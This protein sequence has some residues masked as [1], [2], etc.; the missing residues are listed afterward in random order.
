VHKRDH[1]LH[2]LLVVDKPGQQTT[3]A[4]A[5]V[6]LVTE[7]PAIPSQPLSLPPARLRASHGFTSHDIVQMVR[8]W[9][10][11]RQIGHTGTLD[12][13][14]SGV[15]VLCLG[16]ATRL[17]EYYQGHAKQY[18]AE[19]VLGSATD[20]YDATGV[21]CATAP[22]PTLDPS[23]IE[24]ALQQFRGDI[25]QLPPVYSAL[26]QGG[27][28]LHHKARRGEAVTVTPRP[29]SFY[30]L[31]LLDYV[32]PDRICL[33]VH[34][35]AGTYIRSLAYDL[36]LTLQTAAHLAV[37][38]REAAGQFTLAAAHSLTE[39]EQMAQQ[40]RLAELLLPLGYGLELPYM[41]LDDEQI[42]RF[43]HGQKVVLGHTEID[44]EQ[45]GVLASGYDTGGKCV[46]I[47]RCLGMVASPQVGFV[48]KAEKWFA[49]S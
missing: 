31:D 29:V 7:S 3:S 24:A 8:R 16:N 40:G 45:P 39:I 43:G 19:I 5:G 17:V 2:G 14:A 21:T 15:L 34:C 18:Y 33:R 32:R 4:P 46:G 20:T 10:E 44:N 13:M 30:R 38:R 22:I 9:S 26:K 27:E 47:L 49:E 1:E 36:G 42:R 11:Q 37:L 6:V 41:Q 28:S 48:W 35:S 23:Q 12:P 25:L